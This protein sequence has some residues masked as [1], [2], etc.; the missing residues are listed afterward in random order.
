MFLLSVW[1]CLASN[2]T[3]RDTSLLALVDAGLGHVVHIAGRVKERNPSPTLADT[4]VIGG[5]HRLLL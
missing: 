4:P 2:A 3:L 5:C 1:L